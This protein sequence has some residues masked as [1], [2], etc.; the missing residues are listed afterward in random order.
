M[1]R[2]GGAAIVTKQWLA[3][4]PMLMFT[5]YNPARY[6][7]GWYNVP[8]RWWGLGQWRRNRVGH[9]GQWPTHFLNSVGLAHPLL[10]LLSFVFVLLIT[11]DHRLFPG[12]AHPLS[13]SFCRR[14]LGSTL[15]TFVFGSQLKCLLQASP[16]A[17]KKK[18]VFAHQIMQICL[19]CR[20]TF[21]DFGWQLVTPP[22]W[23]E[24]NYCLK[25]VDNF[26]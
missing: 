11:S 4:H 25:K 14:W 18:K 17:P 21:W 26:E 23:W 3:P 9:V 20:L 8:M 5:V 13:K 6:A 16:S 10:A 1:N 19:I 2:G 22:R 12:L 24:F 7:S 15:G